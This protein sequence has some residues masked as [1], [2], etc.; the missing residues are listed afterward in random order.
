MASRA[1]V[2]AYRLAVQ[3]D[4][5]TVFRNVTLS[6]RRGSAIVVRGANGS[7]K[8]TL[9]R[10]LA[11]LHRP[12]HGCVRW[13]GTVVASANRPGEHVVRNHYPNG[14]RLHLVPS[15]EGDGFLGELTVRQNL[16]LWTRLFGGHPDL[17][18]AALLQVDLRHVGLRSIDQ[19]SH[20]QRRRLALARLLTSPA[21]LWL[22]D[23][24]AIAL[25]D[26]ALALLAQ[27]IREHREDGGI[28]IAAAHG[29]IP[30]SDPE[31][32]WLS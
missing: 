10:T 20:G 2:E 16:A 14:L 26:A 12:T 15:S 5:Q 9:L 29:E 11:G 3:R 22:L 8:S 1:V 24:P 4:G 27:A 17:V 6:A 28:V 31:T 25:D 7:G 18:D 19:I 23:E 13:E 32:V 21:P 30:I